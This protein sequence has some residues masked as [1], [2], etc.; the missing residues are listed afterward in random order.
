MIPLTPNIKCQQ[1][2]NPTL[3]THVNETI[4]SEDPKGEEQVVLHFQHARFGKR[5][6]R[7]SEGA[8]S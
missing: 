7:L 1:L 3:V 5:L 6:F 8:D 2:E 4:Q